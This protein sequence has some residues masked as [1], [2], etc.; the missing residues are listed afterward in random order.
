[1]LLNMLPAL[2]VMEHS[3]AGLPHASLWLCTRLRPLQTETGSSV[4]VE[5]KYLVMQFGMAWYDIAGG[6]SP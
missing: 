4:A 5:L 2:A 1:M 6:E 3:T